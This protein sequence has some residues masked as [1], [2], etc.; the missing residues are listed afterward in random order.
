MEANKLRARSRQQD[1]LSLEADEVSQLEGQLP[2]CATLVFNAPNRHPHET[3]L[4]QLARACLTR[5]HNVLWAHGGDQ[6]KG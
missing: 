1:V 5:V 4:E 6:P 3:P 2:L